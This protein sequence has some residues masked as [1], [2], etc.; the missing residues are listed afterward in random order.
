MVLIISFALLVVIFF[1]SYSNFKK[2]KFTSEKDK[3][4]SMQIFALSWALV[5]VIAVATYCVISYFINGNP[6]VFM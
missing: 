1:L 6:F 3:V 5:S 4:K 2:E